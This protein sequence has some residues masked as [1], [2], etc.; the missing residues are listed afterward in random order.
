MGSH[1]RRAAVA[2]SYCS[3]TWDGELSYRGDSRDLNNSRMYLFVRNE[4]KCIF[5][6]YRVT[7]EKILASRVIFYY[8]FFHWEYK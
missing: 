7:H 2:F 5:G 8:T 3:V 4:G 1:L 6:V